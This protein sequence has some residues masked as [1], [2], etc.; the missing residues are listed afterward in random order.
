M[1]T[2][3]I[4]A[5]RNPARRPRFCVGW[6]GYAAFGSGRARPATAPTSGACDG[7][8]GARIAPRTPSSAPAASSR[9]S[10]RL[11]SA[12]PAAKPG[13]PLGREAEA[14]VV[15]RVTD[16]QHDAVAPPAAARRACRISAEPIPWQRCAGSTASGPS[17]RAEQA[18]PAATSQSRTVPMTRPSSNATN[19]SPGAGFRPARSRSEGFVKRTGP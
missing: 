1:L 2:D 6:C 12:R 14:P 8:L 5:A 9:A 4:D 18:G 17:S 19:D 10:R 3:G 11:R 7:L 15:R 16:Q 13:G